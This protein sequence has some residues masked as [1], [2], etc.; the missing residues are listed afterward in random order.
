MHQPT[1]TGVTQREE[2]LDLWLEQKTKDAT[3]QSPIDC[4]YCFYSDCCGCDC[5]SCITSAT[6]FPPESA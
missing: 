3:P 1:G 6:D 5:T 4:T 2:P